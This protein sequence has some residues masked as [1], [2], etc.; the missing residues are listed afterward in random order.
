MDPISFFREFDG[1]HDH[2][3]LSTYFR[4][5]K[6]DWLWS[7]TMPEYEVVWQSY[8]P[9]VR[10]SGRAIDLPLERRTLASSRMMAIAPGSRPLWPSNEAFMACDLRYHDFKCAAFKSLGDYYD[11][12]TFSNDVLFR[13]DYLPPHDGKIYHMVREGSSYLKMF[14]PSLRRPA[15]PIRIALY[16]AAKF[17]RVQSGQDDFFH[18]REL[19]A[20]GTPARGV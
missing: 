17:L 11:D 16:T 4:E 9:L 18:F 3:F 12:K 1:I 5:C 2:D 10:V 6:P 15:E 13:L 20:Y 7:V 14:N 8:F 19:E